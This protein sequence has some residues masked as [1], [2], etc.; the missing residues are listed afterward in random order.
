ML[1]RLD[2]I[3][4]R[5]KFPKAVSVEHE[6]RKTGLIR[7]LF[8]IIIF[9]RYLEVV[10]VQSTMEVASPLPWAGPAVLLLIGL[11]TL[12]IL[13]PLVNLALIVCL[14][15]LDYAIGTPNL[16]TT[17]MA[18][19]L[20]LF[21][22]LNAGTYYSVD[23]WWFRK[24]K[25]SL[26]RFLYNGPVA[27]TPEA[28]TRAYFLIFFIYAFIS[29]GALLY[30]IVDETWMQGLTI[31]M[32]LTNSY[33]CE[34]YAMFRSIDAGAP[35]LFSLMSIGGA[36]A[37]SIFQFLMLPLIYFRWGRKFV[38]WWGLIFFLISF[39]FINLSMLPHLEIL[40][41]LLIFLPI[42]RTRERIQILYDDH[43]N[44]C[45][46]AMRFFKLINF[47]DRIEFLALSTSRAVYEEHGLNEKEVKA[48]MAGV[49]RGKVK[50][51][52]DLY[53]VIARINPIMY[54][55]LPLF[56]LGYIFGIGRRIYNYIAEHRYKI[57]GQCELSFED[58]IA[59]ARP[60]IQQNG[61][62]RLTGAIYTLLSVVMFVFLLFEYP[63]ISWKVENGLNIKA[64]TD[65]LTPWFKGAGLEIPFVFNETDLSLGNQWVEYWV[66]SDS[67]AWER[68]PVVG[69][70]GQRQ[71][72]HGCDYFNF[73]NHG[74]DRLYFGNVLQIRR[75]LVVTDDPAAY[76][77]DPAQQGYL[78]VEELVR[79][80]FSG[81]QTTTTRKVRIKLSGHHGTA[82]KHWEHDASIF[83]AKE[84][85][86]VDYFYTNG[87]F[88][89]TRTVVNQE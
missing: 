69:T 57:F 46:R 10:A 14:H 74:S 29:F 36:I 17:V 53:V 70:E 33:L 1:R 49:Y 42:T 39:F 27:S 8:G 38:F 6:L 9:V 2:R 60:P 89:P 58:E 86:T 82:V 61:N 62:R 75:K 12:G 76:F 72:F 48:Y 31:K 11:F 5:T 40:I 35:S 18:Q 66:E 78:K 16:G 54:P 7:I 80:Y 41:W 19:G 88:D 47:N 65:K 68:I 32:L 15:L 55:L 59:A 4:A 20:L 34:H 28:I 23:S 71:P 26:L 81:D 83:E 51:G 73:D 79:F 87:K 24:R 25:P 13:T 37:Q 3:I 30:H 50:K 22:L 77:T 44:L 45:K 67:G 85:L 64:Q 84:I 56:G 21:L 63:F 43:C 52:Y